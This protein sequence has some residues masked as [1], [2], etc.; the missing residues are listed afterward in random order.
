MRLAFGR[1]LFCRSFSRNQPTRC[2]DSL[3]ERAQCGER[4][5]RSNQPRRRFRDGLDLWNA[6]VFRGVH[7]LNDCIEVWRTGPA[8][9]ISGTG[10]RSRLIGFDWQRHRAG[11]H[12]HAGRQRIFGGD[13]DGQWLKRQRPYRSTAR[14]TTRDDSV[15]N[16]RDQND[17][18]QQVRAGSFFHSS[19]W[20]H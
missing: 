1:A 10:E 14:N 13:G 19:F 18:S 7:G 2:G 20:E 9:R 8:N 17:L 3:L 6:K 12:H 16:E 11:G 4:C 5:Q 15:G